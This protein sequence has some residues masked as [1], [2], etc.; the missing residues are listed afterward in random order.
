MKMGSGDSQQD[1]MLLRV[2]YPSAE[3]FIGDYTTNIS[4][5]S[6][7]VRSPRFLNVGQRLDLVIT[8]PGLL[9]PIHLEGT[10][11]WIREDRRPE[12]VYGIE[13][14]TGSENP[15]WKELEQTVQRI[16]SGDRSLLASSR[17]RVLVVE[18]NPHIADL[19]SRGLEAHL[20]RTN[21]DLA[22]EVHHAENGAAALEHL[23]VESYD[24]LIVDIFLPLMNGEQLIRAVRANQRWEQ[25]PII[26]L[27]AATEIEEEVLDAGADFF[28]RK[29][30][31]LQEMLKAM[32][33]LALGVDLTPKKKKR[34]VSEDTR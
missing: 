2:D 20:Q 3:G 11:S 25:V 19:I 29:P 5:G 8:F 7:V 9:R 28:L 34:P 22:F 23:K 26:A 27:S 18:D 33:R 31:R 21:E 10:V 6:T 17:L 16:E 24:L 1:V 14:S 30:L 12:K 15:R 4:Q 32:D 13:F